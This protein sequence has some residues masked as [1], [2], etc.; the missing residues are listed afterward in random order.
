MLEGAINSI[1][2]NDDELNGRHWYKVIIRPG[3]MGSVDEASFLSVKG[4]SKKYEV[5]TH[6]EGGR[7]FGVHTLRKGPATH[8]E[9]TLE[10]GKISS[11]ALWRW[12]YEV[13]FGGLYR[14]MVTI[15]VMNHAGTKVVRSIWLRGAW[16]IEWSAPD[17]DSKSSELA[18]DTL[19]LAYGDV[20]VGLPLPGANVLAK[21]ASL[22][23]TEGGSK[24]VAFAFNP[25]SMNV[26]RDVS[27]SSDQKS[28]NEAYPT[29]NFAG[30]A[31]FDTMSIEGLFFDTSE[32]RASTALGSEKSVADS[33]ADI[34]SLTLPTKINGVKRPPMV[35]FEWNSTRFK[36]VIK[37]L[38]VDY[39]LFS[40][41]GKP[42]RAK[43]TLSLDGRL[44]TKFSTPFKL[45]VAED[46]S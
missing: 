14:R 43:I 38:K 8:G 10:Q 39:T 16:P 37:T 13:Q 15:H 46:K 7:N 11:E 40:N 41:T 22:K 3:L 28:P 4:V 5:E 6:A 44:M 20:T 33:V 12:S 45:G 9:V 42:T 25:A 29:L 1:L 35:L 30:T 21:N 17:L 18:V 27:W 24:K 34:H 19:R 31:S 36:G 32:I 26:S 23:Q 2:G